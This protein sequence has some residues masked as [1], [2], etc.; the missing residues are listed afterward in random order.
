MDPRSA[1]RSLEGHDDSG[2]D[3]GDRHPVAGPVSTN[4]VV[5]VCSLGGAVPKPTT[6]LVIR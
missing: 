1:H 5:T 3:R 6:F 2:Q 4:L